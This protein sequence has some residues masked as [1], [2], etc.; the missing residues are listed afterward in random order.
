MVMMSDS[1]DDQEPHLDDP[2]LLLNVMVGPTQ[3]LR[4]LGNVQTL[5]HRS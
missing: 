5:K 2:V 4:H 3:L 1:D